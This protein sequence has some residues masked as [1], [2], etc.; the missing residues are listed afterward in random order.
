MPL[1]PNFG[2][3]CPDGD[4]PPCEGAEQIQALA[5]DFQSAVNFV[6]GITDHANNII[7]CLVTYRGADKAIT[8]GALS[9]NTVDMD[10][11]GFADLAAFPDRIFFPRQ[12]RYIC[13]GG[14]QFKPHGVTATATVSVGF[15]GTG[16]FTGFA[17]FEDR[18]AQLGTSRDARVAALAKAPAGSNQQISAGPYEAVP[19]PGSTLTVLQWMWAFWVSD[20]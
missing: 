18:P 7:G 1:T 12:G 20:Y 14:V 9:F 5:Q 17:R 8:G 11:G 2:L 6:L 19:T 15:T 13:G 16:P 4:D 10:T 3:P